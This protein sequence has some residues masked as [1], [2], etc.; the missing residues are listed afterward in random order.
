MGDWFNHFNHIFWLISKKN[1]KMKLKIVL[2][3]LARLFFF[4]NENAK[5]TASSKYNIYIQISYIGKSCSFSWSISIY[6]YTHHQ[7]IRFHDIYKCGFMGWLA[8]CVFLQIVLKNVKIW[9]TYAKRLFMLFQTF[10]C[11]M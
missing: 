8:F 4:F 10:G 7:Q 9:L 11:L 1:Y 3:W 2:F 5:K 6:I